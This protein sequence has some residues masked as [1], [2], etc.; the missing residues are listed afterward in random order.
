MGKSVG[1]GSEKLQTRRSMVGS[2]YPSIPTGANP[3]EICNFYYRQAEQRWLWSQMT[4]RTSGLGEGDILSIKAAAEEPPFSKSA[5]EP[6][7]E[8]R[9]SN[10]HVLQLLADDEDPPQGGAGST[11]AATASNA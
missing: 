4:H 7:S 5:T 8:Q 3:R 9:P 10:F 6:A 1:L 11:D 2:P